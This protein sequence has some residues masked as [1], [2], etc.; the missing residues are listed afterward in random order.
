MPHQC[1]GLM[2][3]SVMLLPP[4]TFLPSCHENFQAGNFCNSVATF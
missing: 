3:S 4:S 2:L 1:P